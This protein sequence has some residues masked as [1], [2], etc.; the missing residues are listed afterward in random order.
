MV[1]SSTS[2]LPRDGRTIAQKSNYNGQCLQ[3]LMSTDLLVYLWAASSKRMP[4][5][6]IVAT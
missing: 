5:V 1:G 2:E 6:T 4:D 3:M